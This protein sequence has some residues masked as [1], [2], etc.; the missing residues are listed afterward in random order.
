MDPVFNS[1][2]PL[3]ARDGG[4]AKRPVAVLVAAVAIGVSAGVISLT[5]SAQSP[6][7]VA[8]SAVS[9]LSVPNSMFTAPD[10]V[11]QD[12][13]IVPP[14]PAS[15]T[16]VDTSSLEATLDTSPAVPWAV[17]PNLQPWPLHFP[18]VPPMATLWFPSL[19]SGPDIKMMLPGEASQAAAQARESIS[20]FFSRVLSVSSQVR[21]G[22][23]EQLN[24]WL[25]R[26][27]QQEAKLNQDPWTRYEF[28]REALT[29][30]VR[31]RDLVAAQTQ[32]D[33]DR[34]GT[35]VRAT[36][37]KIAPLVN[38]MPTYE[39]RMDWYNNLVAL[40][41]GVNAYQ[42]QVGSADRALLATL[43]D[44]I[45]SHP[46]MARPQGTPP[47]R[48]GPMGMHRQPQATLAATGDAMTDAP[49]AAQRK[50]AAIPVKPEAPSH[51]GATMILL[52]FAALAGG[53]VWMKI[54]GRKSPTAAKAKS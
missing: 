24:D 9:P 53:W 37:L 27:G 22:E 12:P 33:I 44:Y 17:D 10:P 5:A 1:A 50:P 15:S 2:R 25:T 39:L 14:V 6:S 34:L 51:T 30:V 28:S 29:T 54:K 35:Q 20:T 46:L 13:V 45:M 19:P 52:A 42:E 40:K 49:P 23:Q 4:F 21:G 18:S 48:P 31:F 16:T 3:M 36:A 38:L 32:P 8:A 11:V 47:E 7:P 26:T 41:D 43:D